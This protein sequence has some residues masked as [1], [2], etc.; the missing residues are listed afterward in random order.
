[1]QN[2]RPGPRLT[3]DWDSPAIAWNVGVAAGTTVTVPSAMREVRNRPVLAN[4][5]EA[6]VAP[7]YDQPGKTGTLDA[8]SL[9]PPMGCTGGAAATSFDTPSNPAAPFSSPA[10][11]AAG[12]T[13][14]TVT[15]RFSK[16]KLDND[17]LT[18]VTIFNQVTNEICVLR[19]RTW[20]VHADSS[21]AGQRATAG[22]TDSAPTMNP[23]TAAP[24]SNAIVNSPAN[25]TTGP[26][27]A[28]TTTFT[29]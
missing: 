10:V 19:E 13:V 18:W 4:D 1:M 22:A 9:K 25:I 20:A 21:V 12:V 6:S 7:L 15:W 23:A 5:S 28:A 8:N 11:T 2:A 27:G 14:G 16:T 26:V 24:F 17:F 29:K 3:T